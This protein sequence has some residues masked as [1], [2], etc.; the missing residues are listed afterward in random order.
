[1]VLLASLPSCFDTSQRLRLQMADNNALQWTL[2]G[3]HG[4]IC[5]PVKERLRLGFS[6]PQGQISDNHS[7]DMFLRGILLFGPSAFLLTIGSFRIYQLHRARLV[8]K[9]NGRGL[10]KI[11]SHPTSQ[12]CHAAN[13]HN[14]VGRC[15]SICFTAYQYGYNDSPSTEDHGHLAIA[16]IGVIYCAECAIISRA[17][18]FNHAIYHPD[19][20]PCLFNNY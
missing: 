18:P 4:L 5:L 6:A 9:S 1:M 16:I 10:L 20:L 13:N 3:W 12:S 11:V 2:H 14:L 17:W 7:I 15:S 8:T 19:Y